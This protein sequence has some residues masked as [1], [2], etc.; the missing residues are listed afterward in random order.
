MQREA[1]QSQRHQQPRD[2]EN[3]YEG[4]VAF[5]EDIAT[6]LSMAAGDIRESLDI[7]KGISAIID[8]LYLASPSGQHRYETEGFMVLSL[9]CEKGVKEL[10]E[11]RRE[12]D[13]TARTLRGEL[14]S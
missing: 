10:E 14:Q 2:Q 13:T 1:T 4:K 12:L 11:Q 9:L 6:V 5:S 8:A 7:F 3:P